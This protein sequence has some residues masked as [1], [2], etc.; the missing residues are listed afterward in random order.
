MLAKVAHEIGAAVFV[1]IH[2]C[3]LQQASKC[4][5]IP[6]SSDPTLWEAEKAHDSSSASI[7]KVWNHAI[8]IWL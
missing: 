5:V 8:D 7:K 4:N 1:T 3:C 2:D 6:K